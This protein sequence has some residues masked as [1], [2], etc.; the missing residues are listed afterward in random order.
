MYF[1]TWRHMYWLLSLQEC[2][3]ECLLF[4][5][6]LGRRIWRSV[7]SGGC[8]LDIQ[9]S[10]SGEY[11]YQTSN[12]EIWIQTQSN[13]SGSDTCIFIIK[14]PW[15]CTM[16]ILQRRLLNMF[17]FPQGSYCTSAAYDCVPA[18]HR[19]ELVATE[20]QQ[21]RVYC[22]HDCFHRGYI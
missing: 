15:V 10:H 7:V 21:V 12:L 22:R 19:K 13:F 20:V 9:D 3:S 2:L 5:A 8:S 17:F 4:A 1:W 16:A 18:M 11:W 6:R 14:C